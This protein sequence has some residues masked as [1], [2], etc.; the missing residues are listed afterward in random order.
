MPCCRPKRL[1]PLQQAVILVR[2]AYHGRPP[3]EPTP[4]S[5]AARRGYHKQADRLPS[6]AAA[7][8][9][10]GSGFAGAAE[11]GGGTCEEVEVGV[12][13]GGGE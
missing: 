13:E 12:R 7:L 11:E 1:D 4:W 5:M 8:P 6:A 3:A 10:C 9:V 2:N